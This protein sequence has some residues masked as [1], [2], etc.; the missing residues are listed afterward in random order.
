MPPTGFQGGVNG[1]DPFGIDASYLEVPGWG[2]Y[3]LVSAH[4]KYAVQ[5]IQI[6]RLDTINW[7]VSSWNVISEPELPWEMNVTHS[8][9][10][11]LWIGGIAVNEGP[12]VSLLKDEPDLEQRD[13]LERCWSEEEQTELTMFCIASLPSWPDMD[14]F[15][16]VTLPNTELWTGHSALERR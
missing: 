15:L 14:N 2:R 5:S 10:R 13:G 9:P 7:N 16:C 11:D 8:R 3:T 1:R 4:N 12:H 6:G